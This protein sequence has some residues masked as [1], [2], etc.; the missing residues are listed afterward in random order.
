MYIHLMEM[1]PHPERALKAGDN[2]R[3]LVHGRRPP[4]AHADPYRRALRP[5]RPSGRL[6][7]CG[8]HSRPQV[9]G[10]RRRPCTSTRS[11]AATTTISR[12]TA[13]C[14]WVNVRPALD[15]AD[16]MIRTLAGRS[17]EGRKPAHGRLGRGVRADEDA[18]P[19]PLRHVAGDHRHA[20][21][22]QREISSAP[23][24]Q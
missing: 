18:C 19:D 10:A 17:S 4:A 16:E 6:Q 7:Q 13:R 14:S 2:L 22:R 1:S 20:A 24:R 3:G 15:A 23:R 21:A 5:L 8:D 11:I 12:S 9:P